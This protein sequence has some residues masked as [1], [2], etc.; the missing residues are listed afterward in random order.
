[1]W[2]EKNIQSIVHRYLSFVEHSIADKTVLSSKLPSLKDFVFV[3]KFSVTQAFVVLR[4][5]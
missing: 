5:V 2:R 3:H 4:W 1:M